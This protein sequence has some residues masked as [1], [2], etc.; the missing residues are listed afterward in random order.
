MSRSKAPLPPGTSAGD[1]PTR[2]RRCRRRHRRS[3]LC[4]SSELP[5]I[6]VAACQEEESRHPPQ[7]RSIQRAA[8]NRDGS[9]QGFRRSRP[10]AR[11]KRRG[12]AGQ[13]VERVVGEAGLQA[14]GRCDRGDVAGIVV[15]VGG[16]VLAGQIIVHN[17]REAIEIV[18]GV[19]DRCAVR[20]VGGDGFHLAIRV[21]SVTQ[22]ALGRSSIPGPQMRGTGAT[23]P[24]LVVRPESPACRP[25]M[26]R[27]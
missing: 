12:L 20:V 18:V 19:G 21:V 2:P 5:T 1:S 22:S 4:P 11:K 9:A 24:A 27:S 25:S 13:P 15:G 14:V 16:G 3:W 6:R 8:I 26:N 17:R 7:S 23:R 10:A